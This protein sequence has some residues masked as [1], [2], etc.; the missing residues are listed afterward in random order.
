M[1]SDG[2]G[3]GNIWAQ[4]YKLASDKAE[5]SEC[6]LPFLHILLTIWPPYLMFAG[7]L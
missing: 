1:S 2:G 7:S 6:G 5:V 3:A 4:G